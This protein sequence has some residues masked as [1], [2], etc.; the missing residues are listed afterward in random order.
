LGFESDLPYEILSR[1]VRPWNYDGFTNRYVSVADHVSD[2]LRSNKDIRYFI[3]CGHY[4]LATPHF[5]I[6]YTLNH[7]EMAPGLRKNFQFGF[8][9]GGHMMYTNVEALGELKADLGKFI[10]GKK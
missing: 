2:T 7:L 8:Y 4:D 1:Q 6:D 9:E 10:R 5:G 3:A